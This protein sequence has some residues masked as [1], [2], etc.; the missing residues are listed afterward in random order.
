RDELPQRAG[1]LRVEQ[2]LFQPGQLRRAEIRAARIVGAG[3][4]IVRTTIGGLDAQVTIGTVVYINEDGVLS[5]LLGKVELLRSVRAGIR[6]GVARAAILD[7]LVVEDPLLPRLEAHGAVHVIRRRGI[8]V[9]DVPRVAG[10]IGTG[11][12]APARRHVIAGRT[13]HRATGGCTAVNVL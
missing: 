5:P 2:G 11:V 1:G 9:I 13:T 7:R 12:H 8:G 6:W 3:A 4:G 10:A